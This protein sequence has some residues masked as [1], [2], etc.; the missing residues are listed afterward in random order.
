MTIQYQE[1]SATIGTTEYSLPANANYASGSP[2][3]TSGCVQLVLDVANMVAGDE[4]ELR[5]Y[6]KART[7]DT[8]RLAEVWSLTGAQAKPLMTTPAVTLARGW[9]YTLKK[10]TGTD[11]AF[12]WSVRRWPDS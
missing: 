1:N 10:I 4:Y 3:T 5:Q 7:A 12:S 11:R 8:Q 2:Q 6:E 9:D